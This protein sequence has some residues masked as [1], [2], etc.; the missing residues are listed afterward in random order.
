[1]V[2]SYAILSSVLAK[3]LKQRL[4]ESDKSKLKK[5]IEKKMVGKAMDIKADSLMAVFRLFPVSHGMKIR[6][7]SYLRSY[8]VCNDFKSDIIIIHYKYIIKLIYG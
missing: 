5:K 4:T 1:M 8:F 6:K 2:G 7:I 3:Q